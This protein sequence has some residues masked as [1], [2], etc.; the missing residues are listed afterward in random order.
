VK[1]SNQF[2]VTVVI[3]GGIALV[4]LAAK[5]LGLPTV[6]GA[7]YLL[8]GI[9]TLAEGAYRLKKAKVPGPDTH[10]ILMAPEASVR[11]RVR[12]FWFIAVG[13][14]LGSVLMIPMLPYAVDNYTPQL[15]YA[16]VP[17]QIL[18]VGGFLFYLRRRLI[19]DRGTDK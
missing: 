14:V 12:Y 19:A 11:A 15:L 10:G 6:L 3:G 2:G 9:L 4:G 13:L 8:A 18:V 17:A 1:A 7:I 16:V 5:P